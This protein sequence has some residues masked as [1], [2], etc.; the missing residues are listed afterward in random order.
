MK[1]P[2]LLSFALLFTLFSFAQ[3]G[4]NYKAVVKDDLG[5]VVADQSVAI[6]FT[7]LEN[8]TEVYQETHLPMTNTNGIAIVNIGEGTTTDDFSAIDWSSDDH[9][10]KVEID[11]AGGTTFEDMGTTQFMAVPYAMHANTVEKISSIQ[12]SEGA[13]Y[14]SQNIRNTWVDYTATAPLIV[15]ESGTYML[16]FYGWGQNT[17]FYNSAITGNEYDGKMQVR[18]LNSTTT[19][20]ILLMDAT[21]LY[22][23]ATVSGTVFRYLNQQ[24]STWRILQLNAGDELKVQYNQWSFFQTHENLWQMGPSGI[25]IV[26]VAN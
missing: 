16:S 10:L 21:L 4:I 1:N 2:F 18:V 22:L 11:I 9:F 25:S 19:Q 3:Q 15:E 23:D 17:S 13:L 7:I 8:V 26:K 12:S 14:P 20:V 6:R 24:P 5:N